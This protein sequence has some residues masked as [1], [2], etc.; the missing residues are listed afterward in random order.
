[1]ADDT[2]RADLADPAQG[3]ALV[4]YL[5]G[6]PGMVARTVADRLDDE[7][8]A[9]DAMTA[10]QRSDVRSGAGTLN[11]STALQA[12]VDKLAAMGGGR[13]KC[14]PGVYRLTATV[15]VPNGVTIEGSGCAPYI[16]TGETPKPRGGGTWFHP[17]HAGVAF[18]ANANAGSPVGSGAV[19]RNFGVFRTHAVPAAGWAPTTYDYDVVTYGVDLL[20]EDVTLLNAC[21]GIKI[22]SAGFGRLHVNRIKMQAFQVG[23][24]L[25]QS[26]DTCRVENVQMW[27]FWSDHFAV[28][29]YMLQNLKAYRIKRADNSV[30]HGCFSIYHQAGIYVDGDGAGATAYALRISNCN[31]DPGGCSVQFAPGADN[32]TALIDNCIFA[33]ADEVAG[34]FGIL[35]EC[36]NARVGLSNCELVNYGAYALALWGANN[37]LRMN[38]VHVANW[39]KGNT[40]MAAIQVGVSN[41]VRQANVTR[42]GGNG[43]NLWSGGG[44]MFGYTGGGEVVLGTDALGDITVSHNLSMVPRRVYVQQTEPD[45]AY[46]LRVHSRN[47]TTFKVRVYS[48]SGTVVANGGALT[49]FWQAEG[50]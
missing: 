18:Q 50:M 46:D 11:V 35:F 4:A 44:L 8:S 21:K 38:N 36:D 43:A 24:D 15:N 34:S 20:I 25:D 45:T 41:E 16:G 12:V 28:R 3:A 47:A 32:A 7:A 49:L 6:G 29:D 31:I 40:A 19:L 14:P 9:F 10:A 37:L 2:L 23:I 13:V 42:S 39:N 26:L 1:M 17:D 27:P 33:G 48:A 30:I 5:A 22:A